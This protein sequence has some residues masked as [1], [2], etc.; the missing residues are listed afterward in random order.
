[1]MEDDVGAA[2]VTLSR[3]PPPRRLADATQPRHHA[4]QPGFFSAGPPS[5]V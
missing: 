4:D 2:S 1:M 5:K 3:A